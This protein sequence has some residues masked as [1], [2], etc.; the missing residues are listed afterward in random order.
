MRKMLI[1]AAAIAALS[2]P[3]VA[4]TEDAESITINLDAFCSSGCVV[5]IG[6]DNTARLS[7]MAVFGAGEFTSDAKDN[8]L[9]FMTGLT[10][11]DTGMT[12]FVLV[13][14]PGQPRFHSVEQVQAYMRGQDALMRHAVRLQ[15]HNSSS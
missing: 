13:S 14:E 10:M 2:V 4:M 9:D 12:E 3:S 6:F 8:P 11:T 5:M 15:Q 7:E 1:A